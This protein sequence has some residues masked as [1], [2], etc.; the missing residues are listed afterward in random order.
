MNTA[1]AIQAENI[2]AELRALDQGVGWKY[3]IRDG[4]RTKPPFNAKSGALAESD[5]PSTWTSFAESIAAHEAGRFEG[6]GFALDDAGEFV[7]IDLDHC[8]NPETGAVEPWAQEILGWLAPCYVEISPSRT[9]L[10]LFVRG[11]FEGNGRK[12]GSIE[13][14]RARRYATFTGEALNGC[15]TIEVRQEAINRLVERIAEKPKPAAQPTPDAAAD[16]EDFHVGKGG[17]VE[18]SLGALDGL[19]ARM[20]KGRAKRRKKGQPIILSDQELLLRAFEAKNGATFRE[21][22]D[23]HGN[24]DVSAGDL[25]LASRLAFWTNKTWRKLIGCFVSLRAC[26]PSGTSRTKGMAPPT[27]R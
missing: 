21:L 17:K 23:G 20:P 27:A 11:T 4:K 22:W 14:Y 2:P 6:V 10:H 24:E 25:A 9:G 3:V 5:N 1:T 19:R 13:I 18:I 26:A 16:G 15:R 7:F 12:K 8:R